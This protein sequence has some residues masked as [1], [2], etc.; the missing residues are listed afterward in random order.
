MGVGESEESKTEACGEGDGG[1][2]L[3]ETGGFEDADERGTAAPRQHN[4]YGG[5]D[6]EQSG[7]TDERPPS[8]QQR[9]EDDHECAECHQDHV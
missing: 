7:K 8:C 9:N 5:D 4:A 2:K 3:G 1:C 6:Q